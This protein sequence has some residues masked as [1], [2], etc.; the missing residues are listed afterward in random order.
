MEATKRES[1][2]SKSKKK[3]TQTQ[4]QRKAGVRDQERQL[5]KTQQHLENRRADKGQQAP[6][7]AP[8]AQ[9]VGRER[10][11]A[12]RNE[13]EEA[14]RTKDRSKTRDKHTNG[15]GKKRNKTN[16]TLKDHFGSGQV[17]QKTS[18]GHQNTRT[19]EAAQDTPDE[20]V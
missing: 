9:E 10:E 7:R 6:A 20:D 17:R 18:E 14:R 4:R 12:E 19:R 1:Q 13:D 15:H 3:Q 8:R 11:R 2:A 5:T 16:G